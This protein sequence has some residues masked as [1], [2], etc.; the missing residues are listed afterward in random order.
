MALGRF[1]IGST[2][3]AKEVSTALSSTVLALLMPR[4]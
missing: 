4:S 1:N 3:N 2:G